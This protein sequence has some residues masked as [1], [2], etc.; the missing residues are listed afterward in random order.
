[1]PERVL[2]GNRLARDSKIPLSEQ[3]TRVGSVEGERGGN[4]GLSFEGSGTL[5]TAPSSFPRAGHGSPP[6]RPGNIRENTQGE[7]KREW[8]FQ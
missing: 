7:E 6:V 1:M 4:K 2:V 5:Q 8:K 3:G